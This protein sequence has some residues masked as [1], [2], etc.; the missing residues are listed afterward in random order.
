MGRFIS[1]DDVDYAEPEVINGI[2]LYAYCG[3]NPVMR[4]DYTGCGWNEFWEGVGNFFKNI[5]NAIRDFFVYD[6][7]EAIIKPIGNWLNDAFKPASDFFNKTVPDFF[8]NTVWKDWIVDKFWNGVLKDLSEDKAVLG[9][10]S[11]LSIVSYFANP[12]VGLGVSIFSGVL[13]FR[14]LFN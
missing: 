5:G 14:T 2:N 12:L 9:L 13:W 8:Y 10:V 1:Q 3:N 7:Y 6:V 11:F 4:V